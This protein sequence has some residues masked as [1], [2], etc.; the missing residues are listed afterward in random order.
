MPARQATR[1]GWTRHGGKSRMDSLPQCLRSGVVGH[2]ARQA[3]R[4]RDKLRLH[5][6]AAFL[7]DRRFTNITA[8]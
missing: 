1:P 3:A 7:L 4:Q 6:G 8:G 2:V 5:P